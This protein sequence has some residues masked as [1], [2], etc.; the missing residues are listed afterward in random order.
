[1]TR[2]Q[3]YKTFAHKVIDAHGFTDQVKKVGQ[4][5]IVWKKYAQKKILSLGEISVFC[6]LFYLW[7]E[8]TANAKPDPNFRVHLLLPFVDGE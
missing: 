4:N 8:A 2:D 7:K 1:M 3:L 5:I 6:C